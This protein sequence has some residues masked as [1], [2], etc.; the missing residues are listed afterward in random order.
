MRA[1]TPAAHYI[2]AATP[3]LTPLSAV[4]WHKRSQGGMGWWG[5]EAET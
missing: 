5:G 3:A 4:V 1:G 2:C